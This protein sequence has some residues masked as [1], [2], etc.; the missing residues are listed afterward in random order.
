MTRTIA[1]IGVGNV[2][3]AVAHQIVTSGMADDLI[4]IDRRE[5]KVEADA[6]D[7]EDA[8][9]NLTH[10]T[11]I[12]VN[13]YQAVAHAEVVIS[14]VGNIGLQSLD[15]PDRFAELGFTS[16]QVKL[17]AQRL[18]EVGFH[19]KIICISN[20]CD[21]MT[22]IYQRVTGLPHDQVMGT[23]TMLDSARMH[24]AVGH[25]LQVDPR[26]VEGY[27]LGEHGN[28][29]FTAWSTVHV[30]GHPISQLAKERNLDLNAIDEDSKMGGYTVVKGK[31]YTNYGIAAAA[32]RLATTILED[33]HTQLPVSNW[34]E[35]YGCYLSILVVVGR[36]GVIERIRFDLTAD[37][38][39]KLQESATFILEHFAQ[40]DP[41]N[42]ELA[43]AVDQ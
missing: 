4:L 16:N 39:R 23:G 26:S 10:H 30:L 18:K 42:N 36:A 12:I 29:Q 34:R 11:N 1:V 19:G 2:G 8:Q 43:A 20:P 40:V 28:S 38:Q 6:L 27:N 17:V 3:G 31:A 13:D 15:N 21:I 33:A 14:A 25:A 24:R 5:G 41:A 32:T 9:A 22:M 35:E 37:E 7:F